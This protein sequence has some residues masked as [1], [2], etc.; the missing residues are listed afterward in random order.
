MMNTVKRRRHSY[1]VS[2]PLF[3]VA[4]D[5]FIKELQ[6]A[7]IV[8]YPEEMAGI[9]NCSCLYCPVDLLHAGNPTGMVPNED[10][11]TI[12]GAV[13]LPPGASQERTL[14]IMERVDSLIASDPA[15]KSRTAITGFS[16]IGGQ[17]TFLRFIH[18]QVERLGRTFYDAECGSC[19][20]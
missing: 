18:H 12:M 10:M 9:R 7:C 14:E 5:S 16:F 17:V 13:T 1:P 19:L 2:I 8:L 11:G 20:R 6:E 15:V 3:N 4:Y